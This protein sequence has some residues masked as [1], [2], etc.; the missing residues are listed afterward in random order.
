MSHHV[1]QDSAYGTAALPLVAAAACWGTSTV[2]TNRSS[3]MSLH[4]GVWS[5]L[6]AHLDVP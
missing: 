4:Y 1:A 2:V 3:T 5:P 6:G